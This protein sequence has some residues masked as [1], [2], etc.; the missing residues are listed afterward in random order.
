MAEMIEVFL[1]SCNL[2]RKRL[3]CE[4]FGDMFSN[5]LILNKMV[6]NFTLNPIFWDFWNPNRHKGA[7]T[8]NVLL[9]GYWDELHVINC[10]YAVKIG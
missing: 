1:I 5:A 10:S 8:F 9:L 3:L 7:K 2:N 4:N 6:I